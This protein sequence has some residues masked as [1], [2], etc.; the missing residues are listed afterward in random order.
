MAVTNSSIRTL[1]LVIFMVVYLL[2]GAA[3]LMYLESPWEKDTRDILRKIL[4]EFRI[5]N[6]C[7]EGNHFCIPLNTLFMLIDIIV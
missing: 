2:V 6:T 3:I 1:F 4:N 5:E 7:V